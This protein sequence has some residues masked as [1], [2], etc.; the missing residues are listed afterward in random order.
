MQG[1]VVWVIAVLYAAGA[2]VTLYVFLGLSY[3]VNGGNAGKHPF[4]FPFQNFWSD[5]EWNF[6]PGR[7]EKRISWMKKVVTDDDGA[8]YGVTHKDIIQ[9]D[10]YLEMSYKVT[11]KKY[12]LMEMGFILILVLV[13]SPFVLPLAVIAALQYFWTRSFSYVT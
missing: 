6:L 10:R 3:W 13:V 5:I 8:F 2:P 11:D 1:I 12:F 9:N 7:F 4:W